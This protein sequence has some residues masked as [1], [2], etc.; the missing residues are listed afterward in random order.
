MEEALIVKRAIDAG[1]LRRE[2]YD[3]RDRHVVAEQ[4]RSQL[5]YSDYPLATEMLRTTS[6]NSDS[7]L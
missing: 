1:Y 3:W 5:L 7:H 6:D 4:Y 2:D